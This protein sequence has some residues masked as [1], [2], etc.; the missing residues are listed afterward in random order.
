MNH[1]K[2]IKLA[3]TSRMIKERST[4]CSGVVSAKG[5]M[6]KQLTSPFDIID[7][8]ITRSCNGP[9]GRSG[10]EKKSTDCGC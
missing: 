5:K 9:T 10:L 7:H 6:G 2:E 4:A 1:L 8:T 3:S